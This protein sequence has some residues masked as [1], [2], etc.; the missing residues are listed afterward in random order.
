M[1]RSLLLLSPLLLAAA[2]PAHDEPEIP[3]FAAAAE[4]FAD[5]AA[6]RA[7][8][9]GLVAAARTSGF[10]AAEGP[11]DFA[12]G[13]VRA[14]SVRAEGGGHRI[15]E[16]R[17]LAEALGARSWTHVMAGADAPFTVESAARRLF[18]NGGRQQ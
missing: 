14:H 9:S 16:Y 4:R 15:A 2:L 8:L 17:C 10:D 3:D 13:D 18:E 1:I 5:A 11:Y 12:A 6:C 7:H